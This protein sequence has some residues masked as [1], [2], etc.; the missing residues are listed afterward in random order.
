MTGV[1][2]PTTF[3]YSR[4]GVYPPLAGISHPHSLLVQPER[5]ELPEDNF[6]ESIRNFP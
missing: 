5:F 2:H 3:N 6:K 1:D 4:G